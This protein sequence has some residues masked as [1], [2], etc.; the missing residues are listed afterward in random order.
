MNFFQLKN[1]AM[2]HYHSS[3]NL[4]FHLSEDTQNTKISIPLHIVSGCTQ[5]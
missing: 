5:C 2:L 1:N 4:F 3:D